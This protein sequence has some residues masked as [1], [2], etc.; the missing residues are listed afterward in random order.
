VQRRGGVAVGKAGK[1]PAT[2][3]ATPTPAEVTAA[4]T[5]HAAHIA[6]TAPPGHGYASGSST[7]RH[8]RPSTHATGDGEASQAAKK[9]K[10]AAIVAAFASRRAPPPTPAAAASLEQER[11]GHE[12][13]VQ[14]PSLPE[15]PLLSNPH[16]A[17]TMAQIVRRE[18]LGKHK[19]LHQQQ[20][21]AVAPPG[22]H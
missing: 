16:L 17:S 11:Q 13:D 22:W 15:F 20:R 12:S 1:A 21:Q 10:A 19:A 8:H 3:R 5:A 2:A 6:A 9:A 4:I 14:L 18:A 7:A